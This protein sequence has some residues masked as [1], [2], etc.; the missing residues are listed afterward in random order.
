V[1]TGRTSLRQACIGSSPILL[2]LA[3]LLWRHSFYGNG[4]NLQPF[5]LSSI[6][7]LV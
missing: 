5:P 4:I 7:A 3:H 2:I 1:S 6:G